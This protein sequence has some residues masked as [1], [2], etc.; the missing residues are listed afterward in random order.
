MEITCSWIEPDDGWAR[1][2]NEL[3]GML[4]G[5][6]NATLF[7]PHFLQSAFPNIGGRLVRFDGHNQ[8]LAVG[9]LFPRDVV[10]G[11]WQYTLRLQRCA[12]D[13]AMAE[14]LRLLTPPPVPYDPAAAAVYAHTAFAQDGFSIGAPDEGEATQIRALQAEIWQAGPEGLYPADLHTPAFRAGSSLVARQDGVVQAF[15]FG[16]Y[17]FG[18]LAELAS[19]G[20]PYRSDLCIESQLLGIAPV[21]RRAGLATRLKWQ[22]ARQARAA[23]IDLIH[24]TAD[25]LQYGNAVLNFNRLRALA[26]HWLPDHYPFR[27][28]LNQAP[29]SRL[30]LSWLLPAVRVTQGSAAPP[31]AACRILNAGPRRT[32]AAQGVPWLA[33]EIPADWTRLQREHPDEAIA[34]RQTTDAIFAEYLGLRPGAYVI[35]D[36]VAAADRRFL[37]ASRYQEAL[38]MRDT[39]ML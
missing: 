12:P 14:A 39:S 32:A 10:H 24:W 23:G 37:I 31:L 5:P 22:Q 30:A 18:T 8:L 36:A 26:F 13:F 15:L 4:G 34:W 28:A 2:V 20:L 11:E 16:F 38:L 6:S 9:L 35:T 33:I 19:A 29:A 3:Y 7:P 27:N 1:A 17:R 25:P 21:A